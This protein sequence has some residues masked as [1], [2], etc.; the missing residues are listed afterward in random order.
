LNS[1]LHQHLRHYHSRSAYGL[2]IG[3]SSSDA[4][5]VLMPMTISWPHHHENPIGKVWKL[6]VKKR[7]RVWATPLM[8]L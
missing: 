7:S 3:F 1:I 2:P 5:D 4:Y 6:S 8:F